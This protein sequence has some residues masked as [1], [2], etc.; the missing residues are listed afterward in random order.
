MSAALPHVAKL[1]PMMRSTRDQPAEA[2][3]ASTGAHTVRQHVRQLNSGSATT[4]SSTLEEDHRLALQLQAE[5]DNNYTSQSA[6]SDG[7]R[8]HAG[9]LLSGRS[10][11]EEDQ[12]LA[13]QL[14]AELNTSGQSR[15]DAAAMDAVRSSMD[16]DLRLAFQLQAELNHDTDQSDGSFIR[17]CAR[18]PRVTSAATTARSTMDED[19]RLAL[20]LQAELSNGTDQPVGSIGVR[21]Q[22][23]R[24]GA[25]FVG[26]S[27]LERDESSLQLQPNSPGGIGRDDFPC[28]SFSSLLRAEFRPVQ[29]MTLR[30]DP[31]A[32]AIRQEFLE[33]MRSQNGTWHAANSTSSSSGMQQTVDSVDSLMRSLDQ[34]EATRRR[35]RERR[36][37]MFAE[38][39]ELEE[40]QR[41]AC[42]ESLDNARREVASLSDTV[43][44]ALTVQ[45][46]ESMQ[47]DE[48]RERDRLS[49]QKQRDRKVAMRQR[50]HARREGRQRMQD[51][52]WRRTL[53][54]HPES[55]VLAGSARAILA[56][57]SGIGENVS[58]VELTPASP[59]DDC[60]CCI[61]LENFGGSDGDMGSRAVELP[62]K[63][64]FH[65]FCITAWLAARRTCPM[66]RAAVF[67]QEQQRPVSGQR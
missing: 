31:L 54:R 15:T 3:Q 56:A 45:R 39:L 55:H 35:G 7:A 49:R 18:L 57:P 58:M 12:R 37:R 44:N 23:E 61:C 4:V 63:H 41:D 30:S 11:M 16:E 20:Q 38:M 19:H 22:A 1:L 66:C 34:I 51:E 59:G 26:S 53:S 24:P 42:R 6:G 29:N 10:P 46:N 67:S 28:F 36:D 9:V 25:G 40:K 33:R 8:G 43:T 2:M 13:L 62:C 47:L 52:T 65:R 60:T 48:V 17:E 64:H 5:L 27:N 21:E 50:E 32:V 14:D